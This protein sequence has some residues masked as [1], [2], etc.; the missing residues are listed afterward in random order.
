MT[1]GEKMIWAAVFALERAKMMDDECRIG[2]AEYYPGCVENA[3]EA[4]ISFREQRPAMIDGWGEN[5]DVV[6]L[7]D[8]MREVS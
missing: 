3:W 5:S 6:E 8:E 4:V 2:T 1:I 7:Y